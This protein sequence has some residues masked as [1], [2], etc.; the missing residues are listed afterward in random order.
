MPFEALIERPAKL[1]A[2]S[3]WANLSI[4][5]MEQCTGCNPCHSSPQRLVV[6]RTSRVSAVISC[7]ICAPLSLLRHPGWDQ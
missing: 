1:L 3:L 4:A 5:P 2:G 7:V 6:I